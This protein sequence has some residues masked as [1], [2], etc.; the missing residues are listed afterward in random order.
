MAFVLGNSAIATLCD[1]LLAFLKKLDETRDV[2]GKSLLY[3]SMILYG[4]GN[5]DANRH[6]H[7]NLPLILAGSGVAM[8][9]CF[10]VV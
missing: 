1:E 2:D 7:S 4:S 10:P 9:K 6:T 3:N 8:A 5:A